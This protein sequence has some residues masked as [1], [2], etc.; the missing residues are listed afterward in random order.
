[1]KNWKGKAGGV[2]MMLTGAGMLASALSQD[3]MDMEQVAQALGLI[4]AGLGVF[5]IRSAI[6]KS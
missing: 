6:G 4:T 3:S 1:M 5:G 2:G